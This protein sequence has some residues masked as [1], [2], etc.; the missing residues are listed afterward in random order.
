MENINNDALHSI[1]VNCKRP[2]QSDRTIT[3]LE[4]VRNM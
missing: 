4:V 3:G 1:A 2:F